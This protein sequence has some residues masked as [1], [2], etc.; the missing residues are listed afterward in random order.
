M[1]GDRYFDGSVH[2]VSFPNHVA[3]ERWSRMETVI[4][5]ERRENMDLG[6][7]EINLKVDATIEAASTAEIGTLP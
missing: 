5:S 2:L 1:L 3:L 7:V 6:L 4:N